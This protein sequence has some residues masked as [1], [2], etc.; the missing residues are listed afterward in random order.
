MRRYLSVCVRSAVLLA[1]S[2][3]IAQEAA[4]HEFLS[5]AFLDLYAA[6][7]PADRPAP[8]RLFGT[9]A[10]FAVVSHREPGSGSAESHAEWT[11]VYFVSAGTATLVVGGEIVAGMETA[12]GEIRGEAIEGGERRTLAEG[13]V[14]HIPP[15]TAH[16]V[17]VAD[18]GQ[19]TYLL[20]KIRVPQ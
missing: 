17:I 6:A 4:D 5:A 14:V 1:S 15:G 19:L 11:D 18:G 13:D 7:D 10:Y 12:P 2:A 3:V 8:G 16:H 20:V 9:E